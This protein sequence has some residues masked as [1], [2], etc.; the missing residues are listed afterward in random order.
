MKSLKAPEGTP[1][2]NNSQPIVINNVMDGSDNNDEEQVNKDNDTKK[3]DVGDKNSE[4][5][6]ITED[7]DHTK[8]MDL[9]S[10]HMDMASFVE[11]LEE[12][13]SLFPIDPEQSASISTGN[14]SEQEVEDLDH[15]KQQQ[16]SKDKDS[17]SSVLPL[18]RYFYL[19]DFNYI[20]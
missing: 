7:G 16:Q 8:E 9:S 17:Q 6:D 18:K 20:S 19:V 1:K 11:D 3:M 5:D 15:F 13:Q 4:M 14:N 12:S 10:S 2:I